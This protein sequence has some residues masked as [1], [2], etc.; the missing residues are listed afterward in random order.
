MLIVF[1]TVLPRESKPKSSSYPVGS[2]SCLDRFTL[3]KS[4]SDSHLPKQDGFRLSV[5]VWHLA[6]FSVLAFLAWLLYT[7]DSFSNL[8][9]T[10]LTLAV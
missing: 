3:R 5:K 1:F 10:A 9:K 7:R 2:A 8:A 4:V 6:S